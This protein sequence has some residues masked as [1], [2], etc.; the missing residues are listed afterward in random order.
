M[1]DAARIVAYFAAT[2]LLGCL[3]APFLYWSGHALADHGVFS[4]LDAVDFESFFH[5]ALLLAALI[6]LWPFLRWAGIKSRADLGLHASDRPWS[7]LITGFATA[8]VPLLFCGGVLIGFRVYVPRVALS[9]GSFA[10]VLAASAF[11]PL[12]EECFFRGLIL[13]LLL[14]HNRPLLANGLT[15]GV[16]AIVHF[17][18]A[19]EGH[20][21][22]VT[23]VSG[24]ESIAHSFTQFAQPM[25]VLASFATL[26]LIGWILAD[27]RIRTRALWLPIGLHAGW[28]FGNGI[29]N[30]VA[31]RRIIALPWLGRNL[32]VGV[33]PLCVCLVTWAVVL[34]FLH[35]RR[36]LAATS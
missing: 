24:F 13:G 33:V 32:L 11:V 7:E 34:L 17:L 9:A 12:I 5:R 14:R 36:A 15:S 19:P 31:H 22:S 28:I 18:K 21:D 10:G 23:W 4:A 27:V 26:F 6:L 8:V 1:K 25:L 20:A 30:R 16:F 29:F 3:L 35:R 2:L